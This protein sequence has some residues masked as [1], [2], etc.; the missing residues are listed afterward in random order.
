MSDF[1][2]K[3][4]GDEILELMG[5]AAKETVNETVDAIG[6]GAEAGAPKLSGA[7]AKSVA[8]LHAGRDNAGA[9]SAAEGAASALQPGI[10]FNARLALIDGSDEGHYLGAVEVLADYAA[11]IHNGG[12]GRTGR[13]F[14]EDAGDGQESEFEGRA[15]QNFARKLGD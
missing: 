5:Q 8:R 11:I 6:D 3:S 12:G 14:L 4:N 1:K 9:E 7:M 15:R 10:E 13:P 2:F